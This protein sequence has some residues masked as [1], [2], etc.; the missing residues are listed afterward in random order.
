[1]EISQCGALANVKIVVFLLFLIHMQ[2]NF[3][4]TVK[5]RKT[6]LTKS[7]MNDRQNGKCP[8]GRGACLEN[9]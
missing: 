5:K 2:R 8:V 3:V 1:M 7:M 9:R 6:C 4:W